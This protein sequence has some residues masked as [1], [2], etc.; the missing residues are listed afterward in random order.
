[1]LV[2]WVTPSATVRTL[3]WIRWTE[4]GGG[5]NDGSSL[6]RFTFT[7]AGYF[8]ASAASHSVVEKLCGQC[9][10]KDTVSGGV[11]VAITTGSRCIVVDKDRILITGHK[12]SR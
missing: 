7:T 10:R 5:Y 9:S 11:Q 4:I 2:G 8:V 3:S 12:N 6:T 1:M